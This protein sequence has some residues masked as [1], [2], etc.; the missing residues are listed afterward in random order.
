MRALLWL[1]HSLVVAPT[2][3]ADASAAWVD[4]SSTRVG[5][6]PA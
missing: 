2:D 4:A 5:V 3:W 1:T 6:S